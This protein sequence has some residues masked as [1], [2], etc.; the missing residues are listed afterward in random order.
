[1]LQIQVGPCER[2]P[3]FI[4]YSLSQVG[5]S[6]RGTIPILPPWKL[7][8]HCPQN[9]GLYE[10][11]SHLLQH[12]HSPQ[13]LKKRKLVC[14]QKGINDNACLSAN[15]CWSGGMFIKLLIC[16]IRLMLTICIYLCSWH[17]ALYISNKE[18]QQVIHES[19]VLVHH[20]A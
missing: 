16:K 10:A 20:G 14:M 6:H 19:I 1:M 5:R 3:S 9:I 17:F 11:L 7:L 2:L 4:L 15:F 12:A 8:N 18:L 13:I